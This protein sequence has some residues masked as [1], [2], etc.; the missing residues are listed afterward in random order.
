MCSIVMTAD[1]AIQCGTAVSFAPVIRNTSADKATRK[2]NVRAHACIVRLIGQ[3]DKACNT[4]LNDILHHPVLQRLE[5]I[6][7]SLNSLT[8]LLSGNKIKVRLLDVSW[9]EITRDL[10]KTIDVNQSE[11]FNKIYNQEFGMPGGEPYGVLIGDYA[12]NITDRSHIEALQL[13]S[14]ISAAAFAPFIA[15]LAPTS[16]GLASFTELNRIQNLQQIFKTA[17]YQAWESLR[18]TEDARFIGLV[19]PHVLMRQPYSQKQCLQTGFCF[20]EKNHRLQDYVWGNASFS[21]ASILMNSF[22][23]SS[24]FTNLRGANTKCSGGLV[25]TLA[26]IDFNTDSKGIVPKFSTNLLISDT[27]ERILS[28]LGFISLCQLAG[29]HEAVFYDN[30]SIQAAKEYSE[31]AATVNAKISASLQY[32]FCVSRFAHYIKIIGRNKI[33][34]FLSPT[35]CEIFLNSWLVNYIAANDDLTTDQKLNYPLSDAQVQVKLSPGKG[36]TYVCII[37]LQPRMHLEQ[38]KTS[39]VLITQL[40]PV[41]SL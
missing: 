21:F 13:M 32:M 19:L 39:L 34:S 30:Q 26:R 38:I 41:N 6:W 22:K 36:Q 7:R 28:E 4:L 2:N 29:Q 17:D 35:E 27:N 15:G 33:G 1:N 23:E 3:I 5:A 9:Q 20:T 8:Q 40:S 16:L 18:Q 10:T 37:H 11:L 31:P 12:I 25:S 24:W 14:Q